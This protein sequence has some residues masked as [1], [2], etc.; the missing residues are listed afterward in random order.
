MRNR[1]KILG[2]HFLKNDAAL[3]KIAAALKLKAGDTVIEIGPG[4]GALTLPLAKICA[5]VGCKIAAVEKDKELGSELGSRVSGIGHRQVL[6][7][8][9]GDILKILPNLTKPQTLNPKPYKLAGNIPYYITGRLLRILSELENKPEIAVFT[10][11]KE[12]AER[13]AAKPP[14]MNLL[15]AVTQFWA[16][17]EIIGYLKP[18][19]FVPAPKVE[20]AII[21]LGSWVLGMGFREKEYYKFVKILFK[22]PRK[23]V[24]NNLRF[25]F[26]MTSEEVLKIL[27]NQGF[28]GT[29]RPQDL[30]ITMLIKLA[31]AFREK[32]ML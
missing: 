3:K 32:N 23:T 22:Q 14:K 27:E 5:E 26:K 13:I 12:V 18:G 6:E 19:S 28:A 10:L 29:E 25:G 30:S 4:R 2:Q 9:I 17:P 8:K 20:S 24:L 16:E 1:A 15:A 7:I 31:S 21:K 11:Q